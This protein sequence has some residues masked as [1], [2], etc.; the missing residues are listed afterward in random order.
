MIVLYNPHVDDALSIPPHFFLLK[1]KAL[2]KYGYI[3]DGML[4]DNKKINIFVDYTLSAFFPDQLFNFFPLFLRK[5]V[6]YLEIKRWARINHL[7]KSVCYFD[8]KNADKAVLFGMSNK[9]SQGEFDKRLKNISLFKKAVFHLSHYFVATE[10]KA[11]NLKKISS[12]YLCGDSDIS[13]NAYFQRYFSWYKKE[14]LIIPFSV[15]ERFIKKKELVERKAKVVATGTFHNLYD[16]KPAY[17]YKAYLDFFKCSAYHPVR[18]TLF[19]HKDKISDFVDVY[20]SPYKEGS[21]R[22]KCRWF[23]DRFF[24]AQKQYFSLDIVQLYNDYVFAVVGEENVGFP[25]IGAFEA[26]A[27]GCILVARSEYHEGLGM[28]A[29]VEYVAYD[30]AAESL[31]HIVNEFKKK[32][33]SDLVRMSNACIE[34]VS[35]NMTSGILYQ[36]FL[37]F[38]GRL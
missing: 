18:K 37:D 16:E 10:I 5:I 14:F 20:V 22:N 23:F 32:E 29:G 4:R 26:M 24:V 12:L 11:S 6:S 2:K 17:K 15:E 19:E 31:R 8:A 27:C 21:K 28:R 13:D 1:R 3:I 30:G 33:T 7:G 25:A 35:R 34:Y 9:A 36:R 38:L